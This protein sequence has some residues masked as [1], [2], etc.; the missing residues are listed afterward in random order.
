MPREFYVV[1][2]KKLLQGIG[3]QAQE[4]V[5]QGSGRISIP[6]G[7]KKT[8]GCDAYGRGFVVNTVVL[9]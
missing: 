1:Y 9:D 5:S 3:V 2:E 7:I 6:G 8:F 4:Q